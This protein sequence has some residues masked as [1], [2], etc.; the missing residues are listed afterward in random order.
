MTDAYATPPQAE[1]DCLG[2]WA[3]RVA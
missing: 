1:N 3:A 2:G